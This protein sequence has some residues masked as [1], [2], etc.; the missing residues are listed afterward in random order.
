[1]SNEDNV[2]ALRAIRKCH[3]DARGEIFIRNLRK[4]EILR[5]A[6]QKMAAID[7]EISTIQEWADALAKDFDELKV[8]TESNMSL[9]GNNKKRGIIK[10][11]V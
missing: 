2:R 9:E 7:V 11:E 8:N 5:E 4:E 3:R 1:V 6:Q 10:N